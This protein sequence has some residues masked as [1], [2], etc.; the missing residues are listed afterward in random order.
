[1]SMTP[2]KLKLEPLEDRRMLA[3][4]TVTNLLDGP[5]TA[6]G[7]L[8]GS[9]RQA[10]FD[11]N[12]LAGA[13]EIEFAVNGTLTLTAGELRVTS[14][15]TIEG[16][17]AELLTIDASGNDPTPT[18][19]N[20]DG[21]RIFRIDDGN[22]S[23]FLAVEISGLMLTGGDAGGAFEQSA[24][25]AIFSRESLT[26]FDATL[27]DNASR[28]SGGAIYSA[29]AQDGLTVI[30]D[31]DIV[32]N[33]AAGSGGGLHITGAANIT[34]VLVNG[35]LAKDGSGGGG[36]FSTGTTLQ[37]VHILDSEFSENT[38]AHEGGGF[39]GTYFTLTGSQITG[40]TAGIEGNSLAGRGGGVSVDGIST[41][42]DNYFSDN[43]ASEVGG[44]LN[45]GLDFSTTATL[46][47][48]NIITRNYAE[49]GGGG[50][51]TR[52]KTT[53]TGNTISENTTNRL[54]GGLFLTSNA[55]NSIVQNNQFTNNSAILDGGGIYTN[56]DGG[57]NLI[58]DNLFSNNQSS[59][60][61]GGLF[62]EVSAGSLA[63]TSN[64]F[65]ANQA[66]S[67]GGGIYVTTDHHD[68]A[69]SLL[70]QGNSLFNNEASGGGGFVINTDAESF[71]AVVD[72]NSIYENTAATGGGGILAVAAGDIE[73]A[74]NSVYRNEALGSF[75]D[76]GGLLL[77]NGGGTIEI[78]NSTISTNYSGATGGGISALTQ[79][80]TTSIEHSTI[81]FNRTTSTV[82]GGGGVYHVG[83]GLLIDHTIV[84]DN[85]S[86]RADA[87]VRN[88]YDVSATVTAT[89]SLLSGDSRLDV[90][91][92]NGGQ[93]LTHALLAGSP[94][95]DAGDPLA[96]AGT[97][98]VPVFDQ[99]GSGY[100]R[101]INDRIDIGA[102][103]R[104]PLTIVVDT[105]VDENDGDHSAGDLSLREAIEITNASLGSDVTIEFAATLM[106]ETIFLTHG[107]LVVTNG[108][109]VVGLGASALTI[110]A[111]GNDPTPQLNNRD[112][113]G[114]FS[115]QPPNSIVT[116]FFISGLTLTGADKWGEG[117]AIATGRKLT[118]SDCVLTD[119][120]SNM[121]GAIFAWSGLTI[122]DSVL[123]NNGA[124]FRGG[125]ISGGDTLLIEGSELS[126]NL[127][128]SGG[129][130]DSQFGTIKIMESSV[131]DNSA[132]TG[133][134][135]GILLSSG[136]V[137]IVRS[138]ISG[139]S[140]ATN[141][142]GVA[143][144]T[145]VIDSSL[146][147]ENSA[148]DGGGVHVVSSLT[149]WNAT[150]SGNR[151]LRSGGGI[152]AATTTLNHSTIA[153]NTADS[154]LD[155]IGAGGGV[156]KAS[157]ATTLSHSIIA[158]NIGN[159]GNPSDI[160]TSAAATT[161]FIATY[162]LVEDTT[163]LAPAHVSALSSGP[164]N[165][166]NNDPLLGE[167]AH[168]G[169]PTST[170]ALLA[171]SPA[172]DAGDPNIVSPP[173]YDQRTTGFNRLSG[174]QIDIGAYEVQAS[175]SQ[176]GDFNGDGVVN[177]RD[178]LLWQR[179]P[180]VGEL[181][182]W[183]AGYGIGSLSGM[184]APLVALSASVE[185]EDVEDDQETPA[186]L[187]FGNSYTPP[188]TPPTADSS[189]LGGS[190]TAGD[191]FVESVDLA[192]EEL[193]DVTQYGMRE[194]GEL[195]VR[196]RTT[197]YLRNANAWYMLQS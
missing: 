42:E 185:D 104:Q 112:G 129:A 79:G 189:L 95:A 49:G 89:Y 56:Q 166:L 102:F 64:T 139:N 114:I 78:V 153:N 133:S 83:A 99:R 94:A 23:Q 175:T 60:R 47:K 186:S 174:A 196:H 25:G 38:C 97:N 55:D 70:L 178:F 137:E 37:L 192:I 172:I 61:G 168:N 86:G 113:S 96:V 12:A 67:D 69:G 115:L 15:L 8:P 2:R 26:L 98:G 143:A 68:I 11:A 117:G 194:F 152:F 53:I 14:E 148:R 21:S 170:H 180:M 197:L 72:K 82:G 154:D 159:L 30:Y 162:S 188:V 179:Y 158:E 92:D 146:I 19:H 84:T 87:A 103:E 63:I 54:G 88:V 190:P 122:I 35:N 13:D 108:L 134:G 145:I 193:S 65:D 52:A 167:L 176:N 120:Y 48:N 121:G 141:G 91:R 74:N 157:G 7:Q 183:Q 73:F 20:G 58:E 123:T 71:S 16:P 187:V 34:R 161:S 111:S 109:R 131:Q 76:A 5:V 24:G 80:G 59:A 150:I 39:S 184:N 130:I 3:T 62:V 41:I 9:L 127:A 81:A 105:E 128:T 142:G 116:E 40:N 169:G 136:T 6:A 191:L 110:D 195:V 57:H 151:A 27:T 32:N 138:T 45:I 126:N 10:L 140:A 85:L 149:T 181:E 22:D 46:V 66:V 160:D 135:G 44:A 90:L 156:W 17:G 36:W 77:L 29:N 144:P 100:S 119:N 177:G 182:N 163:G 173:E 106:N 171:G 165:I 43:H 107:Q 50:I 31:T 51:N 164:G 18:T 124:Q 125:A 118:L 1:M 93:I 75:S 147:S 4:F 132:T 28:S 33:E 155:G 101:V